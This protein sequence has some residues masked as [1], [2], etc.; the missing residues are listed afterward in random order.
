MLSAIDK[1]QLII[2]AAYVLVFIATFMIGR[3]IM[4]EAQSR[5]AQEN[6]QDRSN[7]KSSNFLIKI[8]KPIYS[9]YIVP[10]VMGRPRWDA[11][12]AKYK[13]MIDGAGMRE[14]MTPDE[15]IAFKFTLVVVLPL[16]LG[17]MNTQDVGI[18]GM[19]LLVSP[20]L[21]WMFPDIIVKQ[22]IEKRHKAI[23]RAMPFIIDLLALSTEA[24]LDFAGAIAKVVEKATP[25][26]LVEEFGQ[27]LREIRVGASRQDA[28]REFANR[29]NMTEIGSFVAILISADQMGASIGKILRQQSDQIRSQ[30]MLAAEKAGAMAAQKLM[31]PMVGL[32]VPAVFLMIFGPTAIQFM[33]GGLG[34]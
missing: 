4:L 14:E 31:F 10:L 5:A 27:V 20:A 21:G 11:S 1:G 29:V 22:E 26:P 28:L 9:Q 6:L 24:G 25:S 12:R 3:M 8:L 2:N 18:P 34:L 33:N 13:K 30:R 19:V 15:F 7:T 16:F 32:G 23:K 17:F